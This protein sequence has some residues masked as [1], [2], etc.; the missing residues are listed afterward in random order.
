MWH[1]Q[2]HVVLVSWRCKKHICIWN[3]T[4]LVNVI[5]ETC[6]RVLSGVMKQAEN[7]RYKGA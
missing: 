1:G 4:E 2:P 5:V 7:K 3:G 6:V